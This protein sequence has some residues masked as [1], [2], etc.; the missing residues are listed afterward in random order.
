[1]DY[2]TAGVNVL[3]G[4]TFVEKIKELV[5]ETHFAGVE[6]SVGL[7]C[8]VFN[9]ALTNATKKL[10]ASTDGVGTKTKIAEWANRYDTIGEC[11]VNH[12]VNDI[13]VMGAEPLFLLDSLMT[14]TLKPERD[15]DLMKGIIRSCKIHSIALL[16]GE[17]AELKDVILPNQFDLSATIIG[18]L[19]NNLLKLDGSRICQDDEVWG[20]ASTGLHTNG[21]TLARRVLIDKDNLSPNDLM[22][23][24]ITFG[25]AL[26]AVH[27]SYLMII[28]KLRDLPQI[29][30]FAH[31][32]GGGIYNNT[33]R[34]LNKNL[35]FVVNWGE[36]KEPTIFQ[37]IRIRG[38]VPET[39]MQEA[40]NLGIGL[41]IICEKGFGGELTKLVD[42]PIYPVGKIVIKND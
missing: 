6:N 19:P 40:F 39:S 33:K 38:N 15:L 8:G 29:H 24:G 4:E 11:L 32:T 27:R 2:K 22:M 36:W 21:Y 17:T 12:C 5:R 37:E 28:R 25:D 1:M 18:Y 13:A 16:G 35:H 42:E 31:I 7:F 26:L 30:G 10:V 14:D 41:T 20:L 9:L 34:L 23:D 3:A